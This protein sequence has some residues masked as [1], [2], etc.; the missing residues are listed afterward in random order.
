LNGARAASEEAFALEE[1]LAL[2]VAAALALA[3][4]LALEAALETLST[5]GL[6]GLSF[7]QA[8]SNRASQ[9][10]ALTMHAAA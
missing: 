3:L 10:R 5:V 9:A 4:A 7:E 6:G 2:V 1:A 8:R